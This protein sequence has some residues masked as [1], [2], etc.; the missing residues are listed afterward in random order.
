MIMPSFPSSFDDI[1][2]WSAS[3]R[4]PVS[5]GRFRFAQ[6]AVLVAVSRSRDLRR[7]LI[8]KGG[9]ALDFV[10][11]PNRS[12]IDLDFSLDEALLDRDLGTQNIRESFIPGLRV[13][14]RTL[15]VKLAV[16]KVE[17]QPPGEN[18]TFITYRVRIR[19]AL[20][21]ETK[22]RARMDR[23]EP[24]SQV[25]LVDLSRNDPV[26][27]SETF[28]VEAG[29]S[30]RVC[31]VEDIVGEKL[32]A[33]LQ[34]PSRNRR[35]PQDLLDIA[36]LYKHHRNLDTSRIS[37]ILLRKSGPPREI[38]VSKQAFYAS[39]IWDRASVGYPE[40]APTTRRQFLSFSQARTV[41]L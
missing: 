38:K 18:R 25:V 20:A 13:A 14:E 11:Y 32:R 12:T 15:G 41:L 29:R 35:R 30:L 33:L 36:V 21:D 16:H 9:N 31:T 22:L 8:L 28:E 6:Y 1:S 17:Q 39:E 40:L 4:I 37:E 27:E 19:Y 24:R 5:E 2:S 7:T 34:Q 3:N 10:W 26:Y 23:G